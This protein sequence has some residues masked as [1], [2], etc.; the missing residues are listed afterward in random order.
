MYKEGVLMLVFQVITKNLHWACF[1]GDLDPDGIPW[2]GIQQQQMGFHWD[3]SENHAL[4]S[5][6]LGS[7]LDGSARRV[8]QYMM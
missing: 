1:F 8:L 5:H 2:A 4:F 7:V 6:R 3:L